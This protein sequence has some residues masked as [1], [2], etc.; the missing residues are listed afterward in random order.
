MH[1]SRSTAEHRLETGSKR[2]L[3]QDFSRRASPFEAPAAQPQC[4]LYARTPLGY[5][6]PSLPG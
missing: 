4:N 1:A 2:R 6:A 5:G 3:F